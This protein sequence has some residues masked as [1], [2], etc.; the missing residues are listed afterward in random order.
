MTAADRSAFLKVTLKLFIFPLKIYCHK[1][2]SGHR[3]ESKFD[4][5]KFSNVPYLE[6]SRANI[7]LVR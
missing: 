5:L 7:K 1:I 3:F 4:I 2:C 6:N